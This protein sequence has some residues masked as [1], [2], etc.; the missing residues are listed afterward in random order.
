MLWYPNFYP[1]QFTFFNFQIGYI[2]NFTLHTKKCIICFSANYR[3]KTDSIIPRKLQQIPSTVIVWCELAVFAS[4]LG[5]CTLAFRNHKS[6]ELLRSI[7]CGS[8]N[9]GSVR[10]LK[11]LTQMVSIYTLSILPNTSPWSTCRPVYKYVV[12]NFSLSIPEQWW[13]VCIFFS[14]LRIKG[15]RIESQVDANLYPS[16]TKDSK[17]LL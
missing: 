12:R 5:I 15:S 9:L 14:I 17:G 10:C 6:C 1:N 7:N 3:D 2:K 4:L 16:S 11:G 8:V 13:R